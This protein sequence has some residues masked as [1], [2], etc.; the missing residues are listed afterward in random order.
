MTRIVAASLARA[1]PPPKRPLSSCA[2]RA[3]V[4]KSGVVST[5]EKPAAS[6]WMVVIMSRAI[7]APCGTRPA[8]TWFLLM[9]L[10]PV[11]SLAENPPTET[12]PCA[13]A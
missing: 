10:R 8:V 12:G 6:C 9:L 13:V 4:L 7:S 2:T 1:V 11:E 5:Y 3:A